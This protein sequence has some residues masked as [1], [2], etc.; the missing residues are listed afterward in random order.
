MKNVFILAIILI[1][2]ASS[3]K[4]E[5]GTE[6]SIYEYE[7]YISKLIANRD[8][9]EFTANFLQSLD[10]NIINTLNEMTLVYELTPANI[11]ES[12]KN[13]GALYQ[14]IFSDNDDSLC[15][16]LPKDGGYYDVSVTYKKYKDVMLAQIEYPSF[17][18]IS[19][20]SIEFVAIYLNNKWN[21][22]TV[23]FLNI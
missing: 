7:K 8:T 14:R 1:I 17:N 23:N 21:L 3:C 6:Y 20:N 2:F 15:N 4:K 18:K 10:E 13:R 19:E 9:L 16:Y 11:I 22:I 12:I 5:Y